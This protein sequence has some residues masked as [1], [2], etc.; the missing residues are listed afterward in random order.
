MHYLRIY[1]DADGNS[2][3]EDDEFATRE[4][5]LVSGA[6]QAA[7]TDAIPTTEVQMFRL[8]ANE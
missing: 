6:P 7:F 4:V 1:A 3:L 2:H 8:P 5:D